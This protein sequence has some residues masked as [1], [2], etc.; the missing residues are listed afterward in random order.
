[1]DDGEFAHR[2]ITKINTC[3]KER[4]NPKYV[5]S[6]GRFY[7]CLALEGPIYICSLKTLPLEGE[8]QWRRMKCGNVYLWHHCTKIQSWCR[9]K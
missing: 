4:H 9:H 8:E 1:M 5:T 7:R 2:H 3:K 6:Y